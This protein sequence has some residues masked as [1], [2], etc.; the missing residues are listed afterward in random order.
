MIDPNEWQDWSVRLLKLRYKLD[1]VEIPDK[2]KGDCGIEAYSRADG[3][4]FQCYAPEGSPSVA[5][6]YEKCRNKMSAD[7]RKFWANADKLLPLFGTTRVRRWVLMTPVHEDKKLVEHAQR[8]AEEI[9]SK[10]LAYVDPTSFEVSIATESHFEL[11]AAALRRVGLETLQ[12]PDA[13]S[14]NADVTT[15]SSAHSD[16]I[17]KLNGKL[18]KIYA[19]PQRDQ[20]RPMLL[21][22]YLRGEE[23]LGHLE[24]TYPDFYESFLRVRAQ[25]A[26]YIEFNS[27]T[28]TSAT[29]ETLR[30]TVAEFTKEIR[31]KIPALDDATAE[32]LAHGTTVAWLLECPLNF[33]ESAP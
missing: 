21:N 32:R 26:E 8:K 25:R 24:K 5:E 9:R 30:E 12:L 6:R 33:P 31:T 19:E 28:R 2:V 15:F 27:L 22:L 11:E 29:P 3:C 17:E 7:L 20:A 4:C 13:V 14:S 16:Q 18:D 1:L 23:T 10:K